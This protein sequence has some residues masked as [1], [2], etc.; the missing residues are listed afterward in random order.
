MSLMGKWNKLKEAA[1]EA[2]NKVSESEYLAAGKG[3]LQELTESAKAKI[4]ESESLA[5]GKE[6]LAQL[7][8]SAKKKIEVFDFESLKKRETYVNKFQ[9]YKD[10]GSDKVTSLYKSTFEVD[11]TTSEMVNDL[12]KKLPARPT[13]IDEIFQRCKE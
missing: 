10:L 4:S 9:E 12:R 8:S 5:S 13:D 7:A 11:K 2:K 1:T 6:K 3:K